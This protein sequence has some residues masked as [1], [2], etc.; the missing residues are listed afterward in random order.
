MPNIELW[1]VLVKLHC[2]GSH[3]HDNHF[4]LTS[5][6]G[7]DANMLYCCV[8]ACKLNKCRESD[9]LL[10][11]HHFRIDQQLKKTMDS[12]YLEGHGAIFVVQWH[13]WPNI[14]FWQHAVNFT[15]RVTR[16]CQR[17]VLMF[18]NEFMPFP[19]ISCNTLKQYFKLGSDWML[20]LAFFSNGSY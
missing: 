8:P 10:Q 5:G 6:S 2:H 7:W 19:I 11:F 20:T 9:K 17:F 16:M 13:I 14:T 15:L 4:P 12:E 18:Q 3:S 1:M